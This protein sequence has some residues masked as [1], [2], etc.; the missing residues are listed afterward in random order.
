MIAQ[1]AEDQ[2]EPRD[3]EPALA[4]ATKSRR[5][6]KVM[7]SDPETR[8]ARVFFSALFAKTMSNYL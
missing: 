2:H 5:R 1:C 7:I 8:R 6:K 3:V 4:A